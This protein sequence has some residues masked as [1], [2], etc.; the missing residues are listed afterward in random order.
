MSLWRAHFT[1]ASWAQFLE[2]KQ[3]DRELLARIRYATRTGKPLAPSRVLRDLE[4]LLG[5]RL[6]LK[7]L[8]SEK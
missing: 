4:Q 7:R 6:R 5:V 8:K 2:L 1:P 3:Q